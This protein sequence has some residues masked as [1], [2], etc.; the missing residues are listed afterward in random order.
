MQTSFSTWIKQ[1]CHQPSN[2]SMLWLHPFRP[3]PMVSLKLNC[4]MPGKVRLPDQF[5]GAPLLMDESTLGVLTTFWGTPGSQAVH[6]VLANELLD[7]AWSNR[8]S[9]AIVPF[10]ELD[11][12]W[13]VLTIDDQSPIRKDFDPSSISTQCPLRIFRGRPT[14][15]QSYWAFH[16]PTVR[17]PNSPR[18]R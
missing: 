13:K 2:G 18:W 16:P 9:W 7:Y 5:N 3:S 12:R 11:P 6:I 10:D 1:A 15:S 14:S 4:K 8:P 17:P